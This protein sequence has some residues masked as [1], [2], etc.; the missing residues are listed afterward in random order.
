M[1]VSVQSTT[2]SAPHL[3]GQ[4]RS[5]G[6][7]VAFLVFV[8][9]VSTV[10]YLL[11][12]AGHQKKS[13]TE[14]ALYHYS[15]AV[16]DAVVYALILFVVF[17]IAGWKR[18]LFAWRSPRSWLKAAGWA[19]V[20]L[21]FVF[22]VNVALDPF[23]HA[24]REQGAVPTHWEPAHT[25]AYVANW[26]VVAGVAP[27]VEETTYRGLGCTLIYARFGGTVAIVSVGILFALSHGLLQ[28]LPELAIFG[29][30]LTW[31]RLRVDSTYPG[32]AVHSIFNSIALAGV[33][34]H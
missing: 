14:Q 7:L 8:V 33:F 18:D 30:A 5:N 32:M 31:L 28:A 12:Y 27:F 6:K 9:F 25:G 10:N 29:A 3:K 16:G 1:R 21:L 19:V 15:T 26:L 11:E 17:W 13:Q 2:A 20:V 24:G 34:F 23:L 22:V 4:S